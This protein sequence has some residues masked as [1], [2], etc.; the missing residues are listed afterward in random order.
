MAG[1]GAEGSGLCVSTLLRGCK[2]FFLPEEMELTQV[3]LFCVLSL[4]G[5]SALYCLSPLP[6]SQTSLSRKTELLW[7]PA[8]LPAP[9]P[10]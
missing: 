2:P 10:H 7:V 4:E 9:P 5:N 1:L 8:C 6:P 3:W